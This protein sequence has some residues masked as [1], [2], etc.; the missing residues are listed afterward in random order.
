ME[1]SANYEKYKGYYERGL[2]TKA[3]LK[4]VVAKGK[5]TAEEYEEITGE[6]YE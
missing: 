6:A 5:L 2:W 4:N 3:M 1:H